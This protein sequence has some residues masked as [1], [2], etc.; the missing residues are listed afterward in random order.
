MIVRYTVTNFSST[1]S[2]SPQIRGTTGT[3]SV[4]GVA[5]GGTTF[6]ANGTYTDTLTASADGTHLMF[7]DSN[8]GSYTISNFEVISHKRNGFVSKWYDQSG[9][10]KHMS[11]SDTA[12][13]P[14]IVNSGTL[15]TIGGK[16]TVHFLNVGTDLGST[17]LEVESSGTITGQTA[18]AFLTVM[19][20]DNSDA[21]RATM[22]GGGCDFCLGGSDQVRLR[23]KGSGAG[24]FDGGIPLRL[25][26]TTNS[27]VVS[28]V[29]SSRVC[30]L[31]LNA[32]SET[33]SSAFTDSASANLNTYLGEN[34]DSASSGTQ[35]DT[36][37]LQGTMSE[38]ILYISDQTDN[39]TDIKNDMNNYYN[40]Y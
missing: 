13:Q 30:T 14:R 4:T 25:S 5:S 40:V 20:I 27:L 6:T 19:S 28:S 36:Y 38:L 22:S 2:L 35:G 9:N 18:L 21:S 10:G 39:I 7:A 17:F 24:T 15:E 37:G 23:Y 31:H 29:N 16:P 12:D 8:T 33:S 11:Q 26:T 34:S 3:D 32:T 1:S